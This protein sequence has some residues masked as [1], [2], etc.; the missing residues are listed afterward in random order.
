MP[1]WADTEKYLPTQRYPD[2]LTLLLVTVCT[3]LN[4][5]LSIRTLDPS[6]YQSPHSPYQPIH[7]YNPHS[8]HSPHLPTYFPRLDLTPP[9]HL[10]HPTNHSPSTIPTS[11][12]FR[13]HTKT[14]PTTKTRRGRKSKRKKREERDRYLNRQDRNI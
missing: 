10:Q 13:L 1:T 6:I 3:L 7:G 4:W 12:F 14:K 5:Y 9:S 8:P 2:A 11:S